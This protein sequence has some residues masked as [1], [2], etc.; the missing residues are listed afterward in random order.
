MRS[1]L[2]IVST[3]VPRLSLLCPPDDSLACFDASHASLSSLNAQRLVIALTAMSLGL[4]SYL[5]RCQVYTQISNLWKVFSSTP[6]FGVDYTVEEKQEACAC[7][8]LDARG[9]RKARSQV[10]NC[11]HREHKL[12]VRRARDGRREVCIPS[13]Q[14]SRESSLVAGQHRQD[15]R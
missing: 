1:L 6:I 4:Y 11:K 10:A 12:W 14:Q 9:G 15:S 3:I 2:S 5:Q 7:A 13:N 8:W